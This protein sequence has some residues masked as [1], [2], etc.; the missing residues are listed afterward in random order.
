MVSENSGVASGLGTPLA[1]PGTDTLTI[2]IRGSRE[3]RG[4][5]TVYKSTPYTHHSFLVITLLNWGKSLLM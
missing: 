2:Q 4:F 3:E 5:P 1:Q